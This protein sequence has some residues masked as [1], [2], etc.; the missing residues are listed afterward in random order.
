MTANWKIDCLLRCVA[1]ECLIAGH[2]PAR[3]VFP[4]QSQKLARLVAAN[5]LEIV[6]VAEIDDSHGT[7]TFRLFR[8]QPIRRLR[9]Q[10]PAAA[11]SPSTV[12]IIP[13]YTEAGW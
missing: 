9:H 6:P 3:D 4:N 8:L 13:T 5:G 1:P 2:V 12:R 7:P 11:K 10:S